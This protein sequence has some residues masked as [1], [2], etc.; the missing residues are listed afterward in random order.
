[1]ERGNDP[2]GTS[3]LFSCTL[4]LCQSTN[5]QVSRFRVHL[6][7][8]V[9]EA[10]AQIEGM[11]YRQSCS[12]FGQ[13]TPQSTHLKLP[14]SNSGLTS[15]VRVTVPLNATSWPM[16]SALSSRRRSTLGKFTNE[17]QKSFSCQRSI[18]AVSGR[19][20]RTNFWTARRRYF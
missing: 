19:C 1:M 12:M 16:A 9:Q 10:F 3:S 11:V 15:D 17:T 13:S 14:K 20:S 2:A 4:T 8:L 7:R 6:S 5:V 18:L